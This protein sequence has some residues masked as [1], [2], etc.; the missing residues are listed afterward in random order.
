MERDSNDI[1]LKNK[2]KEKQLFKISRFKEVVKRTKPH[3]HDAYFE[4]IYLSQGAGFHW[5]DADKFQ[6]APPVVFFLSGQLH[7][8]EMTEIPKGYVMLFRE[9]FFDKKDLM[10]L[11]RSLEDTV[12]VN[13]SEDDNLD[14]IFGEMEQEY[15]NPSKNSTE[16]LQGYLQV[17]LVKLLRHKDQTSVTVISKGQEVFRKFQYF[18]Q[19]ANPVSNLKVN[20]VADHIGLSPQN[21]NAICRK[22]SG[23]SA[24]ELITEQV[25]LEAKRFLIHSDKTISEIAF[26]LNFTDPSHFIKYFKK[27][28]GKTPQAFRSRYFQ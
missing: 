7:Y 6:I 21:L 4:L 9:G 22:V 25:I 11:V 27:T 20:Q 24:S 12:Y 26:A 10:N 3:K 8:W 1:T 14:F 2:L 17:A 23:K 13:P 15:R 18:I 28:V 19:Q 5:I 16:L